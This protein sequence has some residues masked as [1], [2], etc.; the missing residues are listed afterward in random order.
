[1]N[2]AIFVTKHISSYFIYL[3]I[4]LAENIQYPTACGSSH[5]GPDPV[6]YR[7]SS[8]LKVRNCTFHQ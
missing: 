1:M 4:L 8:F 2:H 5:P 7:I 3:D 6:K